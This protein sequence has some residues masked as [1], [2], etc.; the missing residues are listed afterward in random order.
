VQQEG[1]GWNLVVGE[2]RR[3]SHSNLLCC[4]SACRIAGAA[5]QHGR[6]CA[7]AW[8]VLRGGMEVQYALNPVE[9]GE[10]AHQNVLM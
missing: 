9:L 6:C 4:T 8:K 3:L 1:G 7:A 10:E 2:S 5:Q